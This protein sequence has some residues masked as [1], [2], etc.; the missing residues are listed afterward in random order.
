VNRQNRRTDWLPVEVHAVTAPHLVLFLVLIVGLIVTLPA[1]A[2]S[3]RPATTAPAFVHPGLPHTRADLERM[4][5]RLA[6]GEEPWKS[7]FER[8]RQDPASR[9]DYRLRGPREV[10]TRAPGRSPGNNEMVAD[11]N[12]A[13]QSATRPR[14]SRSSTPGPGR[15]TR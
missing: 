10:V 5:Q 15:S 6:A 4:R 3:T 8:L 7:G 12:V 1:D 14:R 2:Q 13:Y 9:A 11:G